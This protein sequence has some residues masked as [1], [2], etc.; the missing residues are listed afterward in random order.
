M[1]AGLS[2]LKKN[3]M[4]EH[5]TVFRLIR[6]KN[7]ITKQQLR[8][9]TRLKTT[10]LGRIMGY[11]EERN[12]IRVMDIGSSNGGRKPQLYGINPESGYVIGV[13]IARLYTKIVLMDLNSNIVRSNTVGMYEES[14]WKNLLNKIGN[15]Y[16]DFCTDVG[17]DKILGVG[18]GTVGPVNKQNNMIPD[19]S[20]FFAAGWSD[21][22]IVG[23]ISNLT[24]KPVF[25][26]NGVN[27]AALAEYMNGLFKNYRSMVY[28]TA[29]MGLRLGFVQN[30]TL[31]TNTFSYYGGFGHLTVEKGGKPCYCGDAGCLEAYASIPSI[32][33]EFR[34]RIK[35]ENSDLA[36]KFDYDLDAIKFD[37]FCNAVK[38]YN[39]LAIKIVGE[40]AG[41]FAFGIKGIVDIVNPEIILLGGP[42]IEKCEM[43]YILSVNAAK[44]MFQC[45]DSF[46]TV[47]RAGDLGDNA[48]VIGAANLVIHYYLSEIT[49]SPSSSAEAG[50]A[51]QF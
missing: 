10:T 50:P 19:P 26:E 37:D 35:G 12:L 36:A 7:L 41:R 45:K 43:F 34:E 16:D 27:T 9:I 13:D 48:S 11:L 49:D 23:E 47:I 32:L 42:L 17:R 29:G 28:I 25:L 22:D 20:K 15:L 51:D 39:E 3:G 8:E 2:E 21:I 18:I 24:G 4:K 40:A 1:Q 6:E 5:L 44:K 31:A 46:K 38:D 33:N 14:A 30:G